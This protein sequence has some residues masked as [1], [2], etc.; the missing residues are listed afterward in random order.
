M[1]PDWAVPAALRLWPSVDNPVWRDR[2]ASA[3]ALGPS[4]A[5][6][7]APR[8]IRRK[9]DPQAVV[10]IKEGF[11]ID[12]LS[13]LPTQDIRNHYT[14]LDMADVARH[15]ED[16]A[17]TRLY[18]WLKASWEA[19]R[20]VS[21]RGQVFDSEERIAAYYR[22]YLDLHRSLQ[23]DGYRYVGTDEICLGI[24]GDGE[25]LHVRR[26]THRLA[27]AQILELPSV[28]GRIT[29]IDRAFAE[30]AT[31]ANPKSTGI[32]ALLADAICEAVGSVADETA[33][34]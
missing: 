18:R 26:G 20:P 31:A 22:T 5:V 14:Y 7:V 21:G 30:R 23:R 29:H 34:R 24:G 13:Q 9:V 6:R 19:G 15:G 1:I 33:N 12:G 11:L 28:S 16:M 32:V 10:A 2:R 17:A 25:I 27:A 8:R 4:L 3:R